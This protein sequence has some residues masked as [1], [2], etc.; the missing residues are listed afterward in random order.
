MKKFVIILLIVCLL[1]GGAVGYLLARQ[2]AGGSGEPVALYD[3]ENITAEEPSETPEAPETPE[4]PELSGPSEELPAVKSIDYDAI[5]A[6]HPMDEIVGDVDGRP[7]TWGD[8]YYWLCDMGQQAETYIRT[9]AMYGQRLDW[10][11]KMSAE[12]EQTF[13][14]Y[15]VQLAQDCI[16]QLCT[17][18]AVAEENETALKA[19]DEAALAGQLAQDIVDACG[20][21]ASEEDF[22]AYLEE[23]RISREM[24]DRL[25][26]LNYLFQNTFTDLY[27]E[28]G[29]KV[30][31][32][33]ALAYLKDNNY[34][35]AAHILFMTIDQSTH[36]TLDEASVAQ[37]LEQAKA[38]SDE[39]R[40]IEDRD[41]RVK[42]FAELKE[43]YC[44]DTGKSAYP[45]GYL[46]TAGTMVAEFEDG[47]SGL[48]DYEVSEPILSGYGYH[49]I[50]RLPLSAD[51]TV[52]NAE[53]NARSLYASAQFS[54]MVSGRIEQSVLTL[55]DELAS[56]DLTDYLV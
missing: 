10:N 37:K 48:E 39:L 30:S 12:S 27:G 44:E 32:E 20:E 33:D 2:D 29:E 34:L 6:L 1:V 24:Y 53:G 4:T 56:F 31:E 51:M 55:G 43:Q 36:E 41:E 54:A 7:V 52:F 18:E 13:A 45:D 16:R 47:L 50:M 22:Y 25:G 26:K 38:V 35:C 11:D 19:E 46:F 17:V 14:E 15:V 42:R 5:G 3:P 49:V 23:N 28:N 8:Y 40:A 9:M 21:G